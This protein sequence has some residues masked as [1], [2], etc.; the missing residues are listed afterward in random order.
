MLQRLR[1]RLELAALKAG[2]PRPEQV[3]NLQ[4]QEVGL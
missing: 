2:H 1:E 4:L 3:A